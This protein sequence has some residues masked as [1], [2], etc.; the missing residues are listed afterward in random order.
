MLATFVLVQ[1]IRRSHFGLRLRAIKES[2][3]LASSLGLSPLRNKTAIFAVASAVPALAGALFAPMAGFITPDL[4][5]V[6]QTILLLGFLIVGG[7]RS[8]I[9]PFVGVCV[10]YTLPT[11]ME[12]EIYDGVPR[13]SLA[14]WMK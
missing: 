9:G 5:G 11:S 8:V 2:E 12:I 13:N 4:M 3:P 1:L 6:Q 14:A 10:L 7:S